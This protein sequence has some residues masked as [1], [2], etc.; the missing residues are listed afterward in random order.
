MR[1]RCKLCLIGA[2]TQSDT[3]AVSVDS[4]PSLCSFLRRS[5]W[6]GA[7]SKARCLT[8]GSNGLRCTQ[9]A[10]NALVQRVFKTKPL[11]AASGSG[12]G[13]SGK[14]LNNLLA[15]PE[16]QEAEQD[17]GLIQTAYE[18]FTR[19]WSPGSSDAQ[20]LGFAYVYGQDGTLLGEYGMG[21]S[22]STGTTQYIYLPTANGPMPIAAIVNGVAYAVHSD[23]LNTPRK[24]TQPDGQV[25]WQ[26]AYSAFGD[27][28]PTLGAK[29]FT[30]ATTSPTTGSTSIPE[31]TF[32][33]RYPGQYYDKESN[34]HYN[35]FR[36]YS[37][38]RGRYTQADPIGLD[39]GFNRFGYVEGN[40]LG[41]IDP[42]GLQ[43]QVN[44]FD[45]VDPA[46][47]PATIVPEGIANEVYGHGSPVGMWTGPIP[48][49][50][51]LSANKLADLLKKSPNYDPK[52][53]TK[54]LGCNVGKGSY[55]QAVA[56]ALGTTVQCYDETVWYGAESKW[57]F[58]EQG[59]VSS[60]AKTMGPYGKEI[61][62]YSRPGNLVTFN[63]KKRR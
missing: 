48:G 30:D 34:L 62:N 39:G 22:N 45:P 17:K 36:S 9:Y 59:T 47:R 1:S 42:E 41:Y 43:A 32:N 50:K 55:C 57:I 31:V 60:W 24:L 37:A 53:P 20:K 8:A 4:S 23:H 19:L 28:Q 38:E 35:Y 5:R 58:W 40:A 51:Y 6:G 21:G 7:C 54:L 27:E 44:L 12:S 14:N 26:W 3:A 16:D 49:G 33:L 25:A 52:L 11:F 63:P 56:N 46:Y 29:R 10:H 15:D 13:T 61:P 2:A 18:F